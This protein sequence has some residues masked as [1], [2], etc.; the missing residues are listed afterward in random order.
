MKAFIQRVS[1][2]SVSVDGEVTGA[3]D[4]GLLVFLG[5][6]EGDTEADVAYLAE[7]ICNLRIFSN[8]DGKF[9]RALSDGE[10]SV[11]LVSQFTLLADCSKG[12]RPNFQKAAKPD[13][14]LRLYELFSLAIQK[15]GIVCATGRFQ[16]HMQVSLCNDGPVTILL[17][18]R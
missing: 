14:A 4:K 17:E 16:A 1:S 8:D 6:A 7:K 3:I 15:Y 5:V 2:A 13:E 9:D 11:L 10:G 18:S 12:R